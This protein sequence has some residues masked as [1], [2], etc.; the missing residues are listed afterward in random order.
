V[1]LT[2]TRQRDGDNR[3]SP[4]TQCYLV[5]V[6]V[7]PYSDDDNRCRVLLFHSAQPMWASQA[8]RPYPNGFSTDRNYLVM[9]CGDCTVEHGVRC[10]C[11]PSD[12]MS[13]C[14]DSR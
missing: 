9:Y 6:E 7:D 2:R 14:V 11:I 12:R 8:D 1:C 5:F 4:P 13:S 3:L 10:A